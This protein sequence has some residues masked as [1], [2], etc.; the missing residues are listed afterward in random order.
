MVKSGAANALEV[1]ARYDSDLGTPWA[2]EP[3]GTTNPVTALNQLVVLLRDHYGADAITSLEPFWTAPGWVY[4]YLTH[5]D[6]G[7]KAVSIGLALTSPTDPEG[8][9]INDEKLAGSWITDS[10]K[11]QLVL[12]KKVADQLWKDVLFTGETAW[13]GLDDESTCAEVEIVGIYNQTQRGYCYA[14]YA[15]A[16]T[17][18]AAMEAGLQ[19]DKK[20][21][22]SVAPPTPDTALSYT[23][24]WIYFKDRNTLLKARRLVEE[25]Y[26]FEAKSPF[27][28]FEG[29]I[30]L[31]T[32]A[33]AGAWT[34]LAITLGA[35][36][37]S[38]F[39]TF[40]AWVSRRRYEIALLKAQGSGN[41]WVAG[42]YI[43]QS[44]VSGALAG[45][46]G[47]AISNHLI[48]PYL[49][50]WITHAFKLKE[51]IQ[52]IMPLHVELLMISVAIGV[53]L[54]A[55]LIPAWIAA[56]Q[57]PWEILREAA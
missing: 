48:C 9:R 43:I 28:K 52:L 32:T 24:A 31:V 33:Q 2:L 39:C 25:K 53:A 3:I 26:K 15:A 16:H 23:R 47:V 42:T 7:G 12:P 44:S 22:A 20:T 29:K 54:I 49:S 8:S 35:A 18:Q 36:C 55:A 34:V 6:M 38:I 5:P 56:R 1:R 10:T 57:D 37:G 14:S 4:L 19:H 21:P 40:L 11:M 17:M 41:I 30:R 13:M 45:F 51:S 46:A 27:D 50:R